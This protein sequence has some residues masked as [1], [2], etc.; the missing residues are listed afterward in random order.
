[1]VQFIGREAKII[2]IGFT[3]RLRYIEREQCFFVDKVRFADL[4]SGGP[5]R[6]ERWWCSGDAAARG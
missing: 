4:K 1:M 3:E 6:A 5:R 2:T